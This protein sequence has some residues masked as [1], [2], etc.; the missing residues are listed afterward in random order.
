MKSRVIIL[1]L[2]AALL[3]AAFIVLAVAADYT[4]SYT[5]DALGRVLSVRISNGTSADFAYDANGNRTVAS[6]SPGLVSP[7]VVAIAPADG[8][9]GVSILSTLSATISKSVDPATVTSGTFYVTGS[10]GT[11]SGT[12][13][14][15]DL[16]LVFV[17]TASLQNGVSYTAT[18]TNGVKDLDG[19]PL[20]ARK[21]WSFT[22][23]TAPD[24]TPPTVVSTTP[25]SGSYNVSVSAT[26][27]ALFSKA[28]NQ[29]SVNSSS[30]K[31]L[32][33][34]SLI[35]GTVAYSG[36][37]HTVTFTPDSQLDPAVTY[38]AALLPT[39]T[40]TSGNHLAV[41]KEWQFTTASGSTP[42]PPTVSE[43]TPA[44]GDTN[45]PLCASVGV[46]FSKAMDPNTITNATF[47]LKNGTITV[48]A[49]VSYNPVQHRATLIPSASLAMDTVY[50]ATATTGIRDVNGLALSSAVIWSFTTVPPPPATI[51]C[52]LNGAGSG[53]LESIPD[54][55]YCSQNECSGSFPLGS[56]V[57]LSAVAD[58]SS[59]FTSWGGACSGSGDCKLTLSGNATVIANFDLKPARIAGDTP[60]YFMTIHD[61]YAAANPGDTIETRSYTF[62]ENLN[63]NQA[64]AVTLKGGFDAAYV[65]QTGQ[66]L[67]QGVLTIGGSGGP[68]TVD[69][70]RLQ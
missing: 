8:A 4:T 6:I 20:S 58:D 23:S 40:D 41:T 17:P 54:G 47:V 44:D 46:L 52:T 63:L 36:T 33:G 61:A 35:D 7:T 1:L 55:V 26:V 34:A 38:T 62:I 22:T 30:F 3:A 16:E 67:I 19:N 12:T 57:T 28:L 5:Y 64:M 21:D 15:I 65:T 14:V 18:V 43:T 60:L 24:T 59:L 48:P 31:L 53:Y 66:T 2:A 25:A 39:I 42:V 32:N 45:V 37:T 50:T 70:I 51:T 11:V 29:A 9:I 68:V 27:S 10:A 13:S 49:S 56:N 69:N